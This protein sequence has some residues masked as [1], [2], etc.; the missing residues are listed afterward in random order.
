[1][2]HD[3][4]AKPLPELTVNE[5]ARIY[6]DKS[7]QPATV[8]AKLPHRSYVVTMPAGA[9]YRRTRTHLMKSGEPPFQSE[10]E[11]LVAIDVT[12]A[13]LHIYNSPPRLRS[14]TKTAL[15]HVSP[16][17]RPEQLQPNT[18]YNSTKSACY[19]KEW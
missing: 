2:Y 5:P 19:D 6:Q 3:R 12:T 4:T 14:S 1:M 16:V 9:S 11:R 13:N 18:T 17:K 15:A 8:T 7:W 10:P